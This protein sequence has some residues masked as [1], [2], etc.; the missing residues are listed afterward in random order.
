MTTL[1]DAIFT[2]KTDQS[3]LQAFRRIC[4]RAFYSDRLKIS[5]LLGRSEK[6]NNGTFGRFIN[7]VDTHRFT[8]D[9]SFSH[10]IVCTSIDDLATSLL[11]Q[12]L[13]QED[14]PTPREIVCHNQYQHIFLN[15][16][17]KILKKQT[18]NNIPLRQRMSYVAWNSESELI[19]LTAHITSM[20]TRH[21]TCF[22]CGDGHERLSTILSP[23]FS[24]FKAPTYLTLIYI[25]ESLLENK[26]AE[27]TEEN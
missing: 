27:L 13:N 19:T 7:C 11:S 1:L 24:S 10:A 21:G 25:L 17:K 5:N 9:K 14:L 16:V 12:F 20:L 26:F 3:K 15:R 2:K 4:K 18:L 23:R 22:L 8:S 6:S